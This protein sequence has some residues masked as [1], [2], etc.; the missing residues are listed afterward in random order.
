MLSKGALELLKITRNHD[1][2][3]YLF[4]NECLA[5]ALQMATD[6]V[7]ASR[8][9]KESLASIVGSERIPSHFLGFVA[10]LLLR[11]DTTRACPKFS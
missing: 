4:R 9:K 11:I 7:A 6:L 8:Q 1:Q 10:S 2:K 3:G 5:I